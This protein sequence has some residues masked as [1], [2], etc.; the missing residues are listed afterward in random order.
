MSRGDASGAALALPELERCLR[1]PGYTPPRR[2]V[3]AL[4]EAL[5]N[6]PEAEVDAVERALARAGQPAVDAAL[7]ALATAEEGLRAAG[8]RLL[9]RLVE[10]EVDGPARAA[11]VAALE[12]GSPRCRKLAARALRKLRVADTEAPLIAALRRAPTSEWKSLVDALGALGGAASLSVL[13]APQGADPDLERRILRARLGIE[14]RLLRAQPAGIELSRALP[15]SM[16]VELG[17][18][19][20]LSELLAS[21]LGAGWKPVVLAPD[22]VEIEH[23]GTLGEL[24]VART[25]LDL[26]LVVPLGAPSAAPAV[27]RIADALTRAE[28]LAAFAA[29]T[30]GVPRFRVAWTSGGHRRAQS[31]ALAAAI[32][33]RTR[34]LV[35]DANGAL[36]TVRA[37]PDASG[38][39]RLL[40]RLE[41]D[42]RFAY[43]QRVVRA[44]S[45]P[46]VAAALA[47][48]AGVQPDEVVWDPFVGSGL[49]L[50][51]RARLGSVRA[52]F[53]SD[54]DAAALEAARANL[55]AAGHSG[56]QLVQR[57][58][59]EF[60][61]A[62]VSLI[63]TNPPMGRRLLRDGSLS[64]LLTAFVRHAASVLRPSGRLV[65]LSPLPRETERAA[66]S[67]G[68]RVAAG[69]EVDMGGFS[70]CFQMLTREQAQ[71]RGA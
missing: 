39:L 69:P 23:A 18:R 22:R 49:E 11:L 48:V 40:P 62:D 65:W 34:E 5:S 60:A 4:L 14:R 55:V 25:A 58:A 6:L 41:P 12:D 46:T 57:N 71:E 36:W 43:R 21:E 3:R 1:E 29:W 47:R 37:A 66:R 54:V 8:L 53:G 15:G 28:T 9:E 52:L 30:R 61:P 33:Q 10:P 56:A 44:A 63:L 67:A 24:L 70:A 50:I 59:L 20:G 64:G 19:A 38:V 31:W 27:E 68:L 13:W 45:H 26:A 16:Q 51:E 32:E 17:C 35:N 42:P 7:G 2:A